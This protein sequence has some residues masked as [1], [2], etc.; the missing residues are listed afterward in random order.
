[1]YGCIR[2]ESREPGLFYCSRHGSYGYTLT[3]VCNEVEREP[4]TRAWDGPISSPFV[5]RA[6]R[7]LLPAQD[8]TGLVRQGGVL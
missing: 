4:H 2:E 1:M 6:L 5:Q 8:S 7:G 3:G